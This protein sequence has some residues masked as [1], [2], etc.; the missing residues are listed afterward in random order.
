[1]SVSGIIDSSPS[2]VANIAPSRMPSQAGMNT[3]RIPMIEM[4]IV[5]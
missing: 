3:S 5:Q 1:M 4:M 2:T